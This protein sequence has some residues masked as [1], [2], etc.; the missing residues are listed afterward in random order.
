[1]TRIT[2]SICVMRQSAR[3]ASN[4]RQK[5]IINDFKPLGKRY[6][7]LETF[8]PELRFN[9]RDFVERHK[10]FSEGDDVRHALLLRYER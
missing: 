4:W 2:R 1:M 5:Q 10:T 7:L 3:R 6:T 8:R 9:E